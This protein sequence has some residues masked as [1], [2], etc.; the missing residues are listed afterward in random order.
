MPRGGAVNMRDFLIDSYDENPKRRPQTHDGSEGI[1]AC[2]IAGRGAQTE[3]EDAITESG[4]SFGPV[5]DL[6]CMEEPIDPASLLYRHPHVI[7]ADVAGEITWFA[8]FEPRDR[9]SGFTGLSD[10]CT[11][12]VSNG[13]GDANIHYPLGSAVQYPVVFQ[14]IG[15]G[16]CE[17]VSDARFVIT[18]EPKSIVVSR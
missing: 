5:R 7:L 17:F 8:V 1:T 11:M 2:E 6:F 13:A 9:S 3:G 4:M 10:G 12:L 15:E 18:V 16:N 14:G